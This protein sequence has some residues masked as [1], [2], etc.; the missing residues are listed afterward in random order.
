[1]TEKN[2]QAA[3][4]SLRNLLRLDPKNARTWVSMGT[5]RIQLKDPQGAKHAFARALEIDPDNGA[6][7]RGLEKL[8]GQ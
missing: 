8:K 1:M 6:A 2:W 3:L 4:N 5:V 7:K